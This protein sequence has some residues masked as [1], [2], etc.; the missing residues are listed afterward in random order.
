MSKEVYIPKMGQTVEEVTIVNIL[1]EDGAAVREGD[2]IMEVETDKAV[3]SIE[4]AADG[5]VHFG[6]Y[7]VQDVVP[8]LTV[9]AVIGKEEDNFPAAD[10]TDTLDSESQ[11]EAQA[12]PEPVKEPVQTAESREKGGRRFVSPRAKKLAKEHGI[13]L[14]F[15]EAAGAGGER[16]QEKDVLRY[17]NQLPEATPVAKRFAQSSNIDLTQLAPDESGRKIT[18]KDVEAYLEAHQSEVDGKETADAARD[19]EMSGIRRII[20]EKMLASSQQTAP[21]TLIMDVDVGKLVELREKLKASAKGGKAAGFNEIIAK[22][23]ANTMEAFPFMNARIAGDRIQQLRDVHIGIA[24]DTERGL[25]VPVV[26][27]AN[28]LSAESISREFQRLLEGIRSSKS[29]MDDLSGGTFTIT[30]LGAYDVRAFTPIIN[31]PEAAI[32]GLGKI[33]GRVLPAEDGIC[34]RKQMTLSLTF[35]HRL[36]DGAPAARFLQAIKHGIEHIKPEDME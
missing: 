28:R 22:I 5:H 15:L 12:A 27:N 9:V 3:F 1:V 21:V 31:H 14:V 6:P 26:K 36:V 29:S 19:E 4:A 23:V 10:T 13:D 18:K 32:L 25:I 8:I 16:I 24:V 17:L 33:E 2:E 34:V 30:N 11:K 35:D 7:K 20:A